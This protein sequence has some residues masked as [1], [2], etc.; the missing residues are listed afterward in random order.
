MPGTPLLCLDFRVPLCR[1]ANSTN[2]RS[3]PPPGG[4]P[5][6]QLHCYHLIIS[7]LGPFLPVG[8]FALFWCIEDAVWSAATC[9]SQAGT[10]RDIAFRLLLAMQPFTQQAYLA[11][12][13][14][15]RKNF[16]KW[17][18]FHL[19]SNPDSTAVHSSRRHQWTSFFIHHKHLNPRRNRST[20]AVHPHKALDNRSI[21]LRGSNLSIC[22][23]GSTPVGTPFRTWS[24]RIPL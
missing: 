8:H 14:T 24:G 6:T 18:M 16:W 2:R 7:F 22:I 3:R 9:F 17:N 23:V 4:S 5:A 1:P 12:G 15:G 10:M 11:V 13:R 19:Y 21:S 20:V